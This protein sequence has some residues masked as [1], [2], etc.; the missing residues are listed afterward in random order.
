MTVKLESL[1]GR[2]GDVDAHEFIP[3]H[4]FPEIF[5]E[6]GQRFI[7]NGKCILDGL[8]PM[9]EGHPHRLTE[10][11]WDDAI[12]TEQ[13]VWEKKGIYAPGPAD[14][15]RRVAV[16]D[17]MGVG[18]ELVFP[19][20]GLLGLIQASGG[21]Q[22]T[23]PVATAKEIAIGREVMSEH[24]KWA[25]SVTRKHPNRLSIVG[26][27]STGDPGLTPEMLAKRTEEVIDRGEKTIK[28]CSG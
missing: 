10:K 17:Q 3:V 1:R 4:R 20:F 26:M 28:I 18:R 27:V 2:I 15:D 8:A 6:I 11:A 25:G 9:P 21:G 12:I 14:M 24:N 22:A 13:S 7:E 5:G 19:G 23:F 16:M